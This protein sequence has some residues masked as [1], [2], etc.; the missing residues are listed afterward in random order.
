MAGSE[1]WSTVRLGLSGSDRVEAGTGRRM[2]GFS[3]RMFMLEIM[4]EFK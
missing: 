2:G 3:V 4:W 1:V